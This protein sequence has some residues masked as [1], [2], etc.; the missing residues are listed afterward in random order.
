L[1]PNEFF[2]PLATLALFPLLGAGSRRTVGW[3]LIGALLILLGVAAAIPDWPD[4]AQAPV[5]F[6]AVSAG[7]AWLGIGCLVFGAWTATR[8]GDPFALKR[9][10]HVGANLGITLAALVAA[11][12]V[13]SI[14]SLLYVGSWRG[15]VAAA[16]LAASGFVLGALLPR[17]RAAHAIHWLDAHWL[18]RRHAAVPDSGAHGQHT[19]WYVILGAVVAVLLSHNLIAAVVEAAAVL[20]AAYHIARRTGHVS[21]IPVQAV[22][23]VLS[24]LAFTWGVRTIAGPDIPLHFPAILETPFSDA[25]EAALALV[26]GLGVWVMLGLWPWHGAGPGSAAALVGGAFLIRWGVG[27]IP[28]GIAHAA[29]IFAVVAGVAVLHAAATGR[30]G[31]YVAALGVLAVIGGGAGA[32]ALFGLAS[33]LATLRLVDFAVPIPGLDRREVGGIVVLPVLAWALPTMLAGETFV[34][35]LAVFSGVGLFLPGKRP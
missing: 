13:Y 1:T 17:T 4:L 2:L 8:A 33:V 5:S 11:Y 20:G 26:L 14:W 28:D 7:L 30:V 3:G 27:L 19:T 31:E 35:V 24:L 18:A 22:V 9:L 34:T 6:V 23:A 16:G 10:G 29:P 25:A 12:I 15:V 32:W 21:A